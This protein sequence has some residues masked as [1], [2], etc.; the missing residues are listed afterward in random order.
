MANEDDEN[1][2]QAAPE[3]A[4][5]KPRGCFSRL[6]V[7]VLLL[8][9]VGLGFA[10]YSMAQPQ[11]LSDIQG[12]EPA[13]RALLRRDIKQMLETSKAR[14]YPVTLTEGELNQWLLGVVKIKQGGLFGTQ[15][16]PAG[17]A[18]QGLQQLA[19]QV[20]LDGVWVR[21]EDGR[22]EVV[23][24]RKVMGKPFT[25]SIYLQIEQTENEKGSKTEVHFRGGP[26]HP[27]LP[28]P[29]C[30]GRFGQLPV[31]QGFLLLVLPAY[32]N[33]AA[34]FPEEIRLGFEEMTR[35]KIEKGRLTLD[36]RV[37]TRIVTG[38]P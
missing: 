25:V 7:L 32:K 29:K 31:P 37:P 16:I 4:P 18:K 22:A 6:I 21:L 26:Y 38:S 17:E 19:N 1:D 34:A 14:S 20:A 2:T 23:L 10:L 11:D 9:A 8:A 28:Y 12:Y 33:L 27:Y 30:G 24:E 15:E 13:S 36:P 5:E 3:T 35:I